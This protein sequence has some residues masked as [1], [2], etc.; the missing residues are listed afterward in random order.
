MDMPVKEVD[1]GKYIGVL[2]I[3]TL[4]LSLPVASQWSYPALRKSPCRYDGTAY[5]GNFIVSAHNYVSHFGNLKSLNEGD[6]VSF[7]DMDGNVFRYTVAALEVIMP[8]DIEGMKSGDWDLTMFTCTY[9]GQQRV[10]VRCLKVD[11]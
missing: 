3:P 2:E 7:T 1:G 9:G 6:Q 5:K 4:N 10:T 11:S 8:E